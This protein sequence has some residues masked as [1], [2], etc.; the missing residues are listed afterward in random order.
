MWSKTYTF[1]A[2]TTISSAEVNTNFDDCINA[3][4]AAMPSGMIVI[5]SGAVA[6]IPSGFYLCNGS[7]STPDL[8]GKFVIG[9]GGSY[10]VA[11]N[12][13]EATH[14]LTSDE[15]PSHTHVQNAHN[16]GAPSGTTHFWAYDTTANED[17]TQF[18]SGTHSA[19]KTATASATATNQNTGGGAAHNNLPPYYALCYIQKS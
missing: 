15:M 3:V 19:V 6:A 5:W 4:N 13:G 18:G 16:H 8:R 2:S 14:T 7:N 17:Y 12:G 11:D 9:A 1:S 10:A